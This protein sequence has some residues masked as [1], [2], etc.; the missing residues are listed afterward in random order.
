MQCSVGVSLHKGCFA[1][2]GYQPL[3]SNQQQA[4]QGV[5]GV[6]QPPQSQNLMSSNQPA[7][8]VQG[9]MVPYPPMSSYQVCSSAQRHTSMCPSVAETAISTLYAPQG[10][11]R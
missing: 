5:M 7:N 6:Q 2:T 3:S 9:M 4:F 11:Q 8:Q 1:L 10:C